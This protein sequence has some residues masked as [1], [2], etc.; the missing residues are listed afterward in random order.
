MHMDDG[1]F[2]PFGGAKKNETFKTV[3]RGGKNF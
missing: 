1:G 3:S 2:E